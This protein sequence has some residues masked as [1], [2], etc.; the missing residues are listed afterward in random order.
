MRLPD[1]LER[2]KALGFLGPGAVDAHVE[3]A[4][5]FLAAVSP[6]PMRV[7]DLGTG[8]GVPGLVLADR[9]RE[10]SFVLVDAQEKRAAF[11]RRVVRDLG[12]PDRVEVRAGRAETLGHDAELRGRFD[13]VTA[14]SF[15]PPSVTAECGVAFVQVGGLLVVAEPPEETEVRWPGDGLALLGLRDEGI[16]R[17][18][19]SGVRV[20]RLVAPVP[21][22]YPRAVGIP[23]RRPLF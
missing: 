12:W 3:H 22:Q 15:G 23:A 10:T 21:G 1:A 17:G 19:V 9:W 8:G 16:A 4:A 20:L 6:V 7:L 2:A 18:P 13:V 11:L 14:R 5:A